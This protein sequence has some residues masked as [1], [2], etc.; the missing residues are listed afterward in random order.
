MTINNIQNII[1]QALKNDLIIQTDC[2]IDECPVT[3]T[4]I[5]KSKYNSYKSCR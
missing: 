1:E 3:F 2:E 5:S 4:S